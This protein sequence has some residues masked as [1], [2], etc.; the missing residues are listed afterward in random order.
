MVNFDVIL[1]Y[2]LLLLLLKDCSF[3]WGWNYSCQYI[4]INSISTTQDWRTLH[5]LTLGWLKKLKYHNAV[6]YPSCYPVNIYLFKVNI[7]NTRKKC[8]TCSEL[9]IKT[10]QRRQWRRSAVFIGNFEHTSHLFLVLL[11]LTLNRY[12]LAK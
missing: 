5:K 1:A 12:M 10:T 2:I 11:L 3:N 6:W 7:R 9:R 4:H 8:E